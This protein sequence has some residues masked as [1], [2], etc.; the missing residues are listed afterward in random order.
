[1]PDKKPTPTTET[2]TSTRSGKPVAIEDLRQKAAAGAHRE[3]K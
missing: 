1:M 3:K 2:V